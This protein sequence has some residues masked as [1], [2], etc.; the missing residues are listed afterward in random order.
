M[1]HG[2]LGNSSE[3]VRALGL[4]E[5]LKSVS[6]DDG[7]GHD[8]VARTLHCGGHITPSCQ[9]YGT[10]IRASAG[11]VLNF[12]AVVRR[13]GSSAG[14]PRRGLLSAAVRLCHRKSLAQ[15]QPFPRSGV[16]SACTGVCCAVD[17]C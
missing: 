14:M 12:P 15:A 9:L 1:Q 3:M 7:A 5:G 4:A 11:S 8:P 6:M 16:V 10:V 13:L 2:T 17:T